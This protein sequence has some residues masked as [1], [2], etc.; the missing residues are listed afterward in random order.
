MAT[1]YQ[2]S[3]IRA[4]RVFGD[5][6]LL[7][8]RGEN[9]LSKNQPPEKI[10]Q[11]ALELAWSHGCPIPNELI[12]LYGAREIRNRYGECNFWYKSWI[13]PRT[14]ELNPEL[15]K[16]LAKPFSRLINEPVGKHEPVSVPGS[17]LEQMSMMSTPWGYALPRVLIEQF[18]RCDSRNRD[19]V[20]KGLDVLDE[21]IK[22]S[23]TPM[24]FVAK[25][26][27]AVVLTDADP[28]KVLG[29][30]L[31]REILEEENCS[32]LLNVLVSI[33]NMEAPTLMQAYWKLNTQERKNLGII[34]IETATS[35]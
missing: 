7:G 35:S 14:R 11:Q 34:E 22:N 2:G 28:H 24:Q 20:M 31:A 4:G 25:L 9:F 3:D 27:E 15:H 13:L 6:T 30:T 33:L 29:H 21:V 32:N 10:R 12:P 16:M 19:R 26:S 5:G 8:D 17:H 1:E 23:V 18:G